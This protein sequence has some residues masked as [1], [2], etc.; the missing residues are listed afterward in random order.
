MKLHFSNQVRIPSFRSV[1]LL[2]AGLSFVADTGQAQPTAANLRAASDQRTAL[3]KYVGAPD[4]N[5]AYHLVN[6]IPGD[7]HTAFVLEMTSQAWLTTN[8]VDR[9]VWEH[10]LTIVKP[11]AVGTSKSLLFIAG[12]SNG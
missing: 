7:G 2:A 8:E 5:Y 1:F 3:D 9:P 6:T 10:W 12:G 11:D 4:S